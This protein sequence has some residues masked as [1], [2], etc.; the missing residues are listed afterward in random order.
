[1]QGI[2]KNIWV[3]NSKYIYLDIKETSTWFFQSGCSQKSIVKSRE[4]VSLEIIKIDNLNLFL[5]Y[6]FH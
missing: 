3:G 4:N 1:M 5:Q 6:K 2:L